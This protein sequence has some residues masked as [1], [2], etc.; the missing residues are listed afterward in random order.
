MDSGLLRTTSPDG[1]RGYTERVLKRL[2]PD[3]PL[4][5]NLQNLLDDVKCY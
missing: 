5:I 4:M 1:A 2:A 3:C